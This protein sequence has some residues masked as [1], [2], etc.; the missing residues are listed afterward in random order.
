VPE[1]SLLPH[2]TFEQQA[3][4]PYGELHVEIAQWASLV[5]I[6][7]LAQL[8]VEPGDFPFLDQLYGHDPRVVQE[9]AAR[10]PDGFPWLDG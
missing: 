7:P 3:P 6:Q 2:D 5:P 10:D 1:Y 4:Q 9:R 8:P